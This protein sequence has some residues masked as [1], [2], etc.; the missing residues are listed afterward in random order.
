MAI[1]TMATAS[2][3]P[4]KLWLQPANGH[5]NYGY[6]QRIERSERESVDIVFLAKAS[7][8]IASPAKR[9][10]RRP[11]QTADDQYFILL[12]FDFVITDNKTSHLFIVIVIVIV[13]I[14]RNDNL[15]IV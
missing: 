14:L 5:R 4:S 9:S 6:S 2:E 8:W 12:F 1:E 15:K 3:W 10:N 7:D 11:Q 13:V